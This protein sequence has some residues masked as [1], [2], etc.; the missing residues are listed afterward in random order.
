MRSVKTILSILRVVIFGLSAL[1]LM[2]AR[3]DFSG[4]WVLDKEKTKFVPQE[5][6]SFTLVVQQSAQQITVKTF[7]D[8]DVKVPDITGHLLTGYL[9]PGMIS[10]I[11]LEPGSLVFTTMIPELTYLLDG[12]E[13]TTP[14]LGFVDQTVKLQAK[15]ANG[16]KALNVSFVQV[17]RLRNESATPAPGF[18]N[19]ERWTLSEDGEVLTVRRSVTT[20]VGADTVDII[21]RKGKRDLDPQN[22]NLHFS[23]GYALA[24]KGDWDGAIAEYREAVRLNPKNDNAHADLG[25]ALGNKGD[26]DGAIAEYREALRL[27]P[28]NDGAHVNLGR[29]LGNKGDWDG[30]IQEERQA[31]LLNP[32]NDDAHVSLGHALAN[33]DD[34]DGAIVEYRKALRLNPGNDDAHVSLGHALANK[35]DWDGAIAEYR[36]AL[37]LNANN[38]WA[39]FNLGAG[40]ENQ[41]D[42]QGAVQEYRTACALDPKNSDY[43]QAYE[44]FL[45]QQQQNK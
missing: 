42:R 2:A 17:E 13:T 41:G 37:H 11:R 20:G 44:R 39:H 45:Q 16:M 34:F 38:A 40:L 31:L 8:G 19:K 32:S 3:P 14:V 29:E 4:V 35:D 23:L 9:A 28:N 7:V 21:F 26:W 43:Q 1:P 33:K 10:N 27:N 36:Q 24:H 6:K 5:L 18:A 22:T 15:W 12:R 25:M 30:E